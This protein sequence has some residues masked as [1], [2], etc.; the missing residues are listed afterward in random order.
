M[1]K[2]RILMLGG[3]A[4]GDY[5]L[6][7]LAAALQ[8]EGYAALPIPLPLPQ[9]EDLAAALEAVCRQYALGADDVVLGWSLGGQLAALLAQAAG[10]RLVTL[11]SSPKFCA[12][13]DWAGG[14]AAEV[15]ARFVRRQEAQPEHNVAQFAALAGMGDDSP[16]L[17]QIV[18]EVRARVPEGEGQAAVNLRHLGWLARLDTFDCLHRLSVPQLHLLGENDVLFDSA[19]VAARLPQRPDVQVRLLAGAGHLLPL[20]RAQACAEAVHAFLIP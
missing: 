6:C 8:D 16:Q 15:F 20:T 4:L 17:R 7:D 1:I 19:A 10:C 2:R 14:M 3:F 18:R 5:P 9:D 13:E 12:D 11:A